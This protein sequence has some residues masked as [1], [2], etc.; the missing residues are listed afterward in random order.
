MQKQ[1]RP[2]SVTKLPIQN[3]EN[4]NLTFSITQNN[5]VG[6]ISG[7]KA[8]ILKNQETIDRPYFQ[9]NDL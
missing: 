3:Q 6:S 4:L 1:P 9:D 8:M 2:L 5:V 7:A